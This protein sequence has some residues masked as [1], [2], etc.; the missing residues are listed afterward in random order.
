[1][2]IKKDSMKIN[3]ND[4][5]I[6]LRMFSATKRCQIRGSADR[7]TLKSRDA[8]GK[9]VRTFETNTNYCGVCRK[10]IRIPKQNRDTRVAWA[11]GKGRWTVDHNWSKVIFSDE[12]KVVLGQNN[13]VYIWRQAGE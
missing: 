1:M 13:R 9:R 12:C 8:P 3:F 10:K 11:K 5:I 4:M 7:R 6:V 2:V